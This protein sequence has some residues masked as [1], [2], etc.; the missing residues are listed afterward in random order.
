MKKLLIIFLIFVCGS[1]NDTPTTEDTELI[2]K[3]TKRFIEES[4]IIAKELDTLSIFIINK[5]KEIKLD[6]IYK[7]YIK[8]KQTEQ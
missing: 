1:C 4:E 5:A 2:I 7:S 3:E 8:W 6:S